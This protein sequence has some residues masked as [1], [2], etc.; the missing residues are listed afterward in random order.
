MRSTSII[1]TTSWQTALRCHH[2]WVHRVVVLNKPFDVV[3][4]FTLPATAK[5]NTKT[6][7]EFVTTPN[8]YPAGLLDRDSEGL[9]LLT[10][11]GS[12]QHRLTDPRHGHERT[13]FAQVEGQPDRFA[14]AA[15]SNG[16]IELDGQ[17]CRLADAH[18]I[19]EPSWLWA[20][21]PPIRS[22]AA[23]ADSWV[24]LTL[25]EG[26]NRQI[27]RMT[28]AVGHPTLRLI[29]VAMAGVGLDGLAPGR[30][31]HDSFDL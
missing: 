29:R 7:A 19:D 8:L 27:R 30:W 23:I 4:R 20:R 15:L 2:E 9:V 13:Y 12:L 18:P 11:N 22:R 31:R 14:F 10:D 3:C 1:G 25:T 16:S 24:S 5:P 17:R 6:L 28:A 21:T 26:R